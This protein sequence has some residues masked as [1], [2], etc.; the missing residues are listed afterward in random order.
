MSA[1]QSN[2]LTG[3]IS[4][5][6]YIPFNESEW[7]TIKIGTYVRILLKNNSSTKGGRLVSINKIQDSDKVEFSVKHHNCKN[8]SKV[9]IDDIQKIY[10]LKDDKKTSNKETKEEGDKT[11]INEGDKESKEEGNKETKE[12]GN[13][14]S[15]EEGNK[16]SKEEG[17]KSIP[18]EAIPKNKK[19]SDVIS[20]DSIKVIKYITPRLEL[21]EDKVKTIESNIKKIIEILKSK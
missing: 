7:L 16:E 8:H 12:E 9:H 1:E 2:F 6:T 19:S 14:E 3:T 13:K 5:K 17:G 11:E 21:L 15:K 18:A 10:Q 20:L 4:E